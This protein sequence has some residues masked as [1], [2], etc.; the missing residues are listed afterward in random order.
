MSLSPFFVTPATFEPGSILFKDKNIWIPDKSTREQQ[1]GSHS[2]CPSPLNVSIRGPNNGGKRSYGSQMKEQKK[3]KLGFPIKNFGH[4]ERG[5][6]FLNGSV[7]N[8][9]YSKANDKGYS[10]R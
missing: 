9:Y 10:K 8:P 4:Y 2:L 7:R 5:L 3:Q 1:R 6:S